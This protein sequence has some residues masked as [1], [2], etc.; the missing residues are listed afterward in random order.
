MRHVNRG[1]KNLDAWLSRTIT[2]AGE[3]AWGL[4]EALRHERGSAARRTQRV[5]RKATLL[6]RNGARTGGNALPRVSVVRIPALSASQSARGCWGGGRSAPSSGR[7]KPAQ[8][9]VARPRPASRASTAAPLELRG[10]SPAMPAER[11]PCPRALCRGAI[12]R[13]SAPPCCYE[14]EVHVHVD[15]REQVPPL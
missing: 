13:R 8:G 2:A 12:G 11:T 9:H 3:T 7:G 5:P 15:E 6:P 14:G 4:D 10:V 1:A